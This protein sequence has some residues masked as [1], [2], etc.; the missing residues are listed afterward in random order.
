[1][2]TTHLGNDFHLYELKWTPNE[3]VLSL[4]GQVYGTININLRTSALKSNIKKASEWNANNLL[5]PF[6]KEVFILILIIKYVCINCNDEFHLLLFQHFI[7][8]GVSVGGIKYFHDSVLDGITKVKKPWKNSDPR[9]E[10]LFY[11]NKASWYSTW[12]SPA[13][14]VDYLKIYSI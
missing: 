13:L 11:M 6:D 8:I 2:T 3:I 14:E 1:M 10:R 7:A 9:G 5:A 12:K 4:D